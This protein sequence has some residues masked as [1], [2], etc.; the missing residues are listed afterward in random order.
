MRQSNNVILI[1]GGTAGIGRALAERFHQAGNRVIIAGRRQSAIDE[2]T[3][4]NPGMTGYV[5]DM[6]SAKDI[7]ALAAKV[8]VDHPALNVVIANAGIMRTERASRRRDLSDSLETI[9]TNLIAPI[10]LIDALVDHL[11]A[12]KD[13]AIVTVSSGLAF[14][15]LAWTPTYSATKAAIHSYSQSLRYQLDGKV[16]VIELAPPGVQTDLT[17][18]QSTRDEYMPLTDFIDA[19]M[20]QFA[21]QPTPA[22]MPIQRAQMLRR[23]EAEGQFDAIFAALNDGYRKH[24]ND[25]GN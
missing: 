11:A 21:R 14:V 9:A 3:A 12:Q 6:A 8:I 1:T 23:A 19:V 18:G 24:M 22:E 10:R 17:P 7:E 4:A 13:A 16:E 5:A 15:P 20:E 25:G 2:I